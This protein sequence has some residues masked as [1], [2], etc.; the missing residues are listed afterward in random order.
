MKNADLPLTQTPNAPESF[1]YAM[2]RSGNVDIVQTKPSKEGVA[3]MVEGRIAQY[4]Q[5]P[6]PSDG[7]R[8]RG[9]SLT[10]NR[11]AVNSSATTL[12]LLEEKEVTDSPVD[13]TKLLEE[14]EGVMVEGRNAQYHHYC[15]DPPDG[16]R[17][18]SLFCL[19]IGKEDVKSTGHKA[20]E[21]QESDSD[22]LHTHL[23]G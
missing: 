7:V 3:L 10:D 2:N 22:S 11:L 18:R 21:T 20:N 5:C 17:G 19:A 23:I 4:H 13:S 14:G 1:S 8:G 16:V 9:P 15:P 12:A 6:T